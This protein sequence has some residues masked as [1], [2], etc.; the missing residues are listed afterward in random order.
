MWAPFI[1]NSECSIVCCG[2][3][4]PLALCSATRLFV[5]AALFCF[6]VL[7]FKKWLVPE[8]YLEK[9]TN[10]QIARKVWGLTTRSKCKCTFAT[11]TVPQSLLLSSGFFLKKYSN[12]PVIL[13][14][15]HLNHTHL[16]FTPNIFTA[17]FV[18]SKC[19]FLSL[20][21]KKNVQMRCYNK[22]HNCC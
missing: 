7:I 3:L 14:S 21:Q 19:K 20:P 16:Y 22:W 2:G 12:F 9:S 15:R 5:D 1:Q 6:F 11:Y 18:P 17:S 4:L 8:G 13:N 10:I